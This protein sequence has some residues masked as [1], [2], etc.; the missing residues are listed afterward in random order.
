LESLVFYCLAA[1]ILGLAL[2]VVTTTRILRAVVSLFLALA[3]VSGL[4]FL[5]R[6]PILGAM[7]LMVYAGG[8]AVL[9]AFAVMLVR[10]IT[11]AHVRHTTGYAGP[12]A[13]V[14]AG[15][16]LLLATIWAA[17]LGLGLEDNA[18]ASGKPGL[19][20]D[21]AQRVVDTKSP[22]EIDPKEDFSPL[23]LRDYL[24][25]FEIASVLLLVAMVGAVLIAHPLGRTHHE[26]AGDVTREGT[27]AI[28]GR[29]AAE[30]PSGA[31][32]AKGG[33]G[34]DV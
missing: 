1:T 9:F 5:L 24:M 2:V 16:V 29:G 19:A 17:Q 33:G 15:F 14:A 18:A 31:P 26:E 25:P 20:A 30:A 28:V 7:Q 12:G 27:D 4:F 3:G 6:A 11:G 21:L 34:H 22:P 8:I 13:L 10:S 32:D 23:I